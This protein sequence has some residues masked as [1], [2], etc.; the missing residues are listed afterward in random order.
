MKAINKLACAVI[1]SIILVGCSS[2]PVSQPLIDSFENAAKRVDIWSSI[3]YELITDESLIKQVEP[4][5]EPGSILVN[6]MVDLM[7]RGEMRAD[8]IHYT[9]NEAVPYRYTHGSGTDEPGHG[10]LDQGE[11]Y[12]MYRYYTFSNMDDVNDFI[13]NSVIRVEWKEEESNNQ[14]L[15]KL[16]GKP[17]Q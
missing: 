5:A 14:L 3:H 12:R 2:E 17:T 13:S 1:C 11:Q 8:A 16:P 15:L 7:N 9:F 10:Y 4:S 6:I